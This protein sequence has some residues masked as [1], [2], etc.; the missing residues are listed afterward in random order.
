M[1]IRSSKFFLLSLSGTLLLA[2]C[3]QP[4]TPPE[5]KVPPVVTVQ[6][7]QV[8]GV[9]SV[10]RAGEAVAGATVSVEGETT[11]T[12]TDAN[13]RYALAVPV[14]ASKYRNLLITK[15]DYASTR[16]ENVDVSAPQVLNEILQR[17]FDPA[18]PS[19]PPKVTVVRQT[20]ND[21]GEVTSSA[22]F[23]DGDTIDVSSPTSPA[24]FLEV[25]TTTASPDLNGPATG[26]ASV[27]AE[28]GSSG[29]LNNGRTRVLLSQLTGSDTFTFKAADLAAFS[30]NTDIHINIYDYN[31]NRTH[32]IRH[33]KVGSAA[34]T[35]AVIAPTN[36]APLAIT[37]ADTATYGKLSQNPQVADAL[38]AWVKTGNA[39]G[40]RTLNQASAQGVSPQ[41]LTPQAA[42]AGTVTW[43]D[44]NF[45]YDPAA[46]QPRSFELYRSLDGKKT[47][48]KVLSAAPAR[49]LKDAKKPETG[50]F[51]M[52][53]NSAE[54]TPGTEVSYKVRAVSDAGGQDS[55]A[56]S[57]TPLGRYSI[58]LGAPGRAAT[59]VDTQPIFRWKTRGASDKEALL[60]LLLDRTQAEG[61]SSQWESDVSDSSSVIYNADWLARTPYLQPFHA[62]DWQLAGVTYNTAK[63]A[64]SV[65][66]DYFNVLGITANP[67]KSGPI[68]EFVTGGY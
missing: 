29:Y 61:K 44:V 17:S 12:T 33:V 54:L 49:V 59:G 14:T 53:D 55:E 6:T 57:V 63:T 51:L 66:A 21:K 1:S 19:T 24:L 25:T 20:K 56:T 7:V 43:V 45:K 32:L 23:V 3:S 65:G 41:L 18:L 60:L 15:A 40:L 5:I 36:L 64:Y 9:V 47:Y 27:G 46:P 28:A 37:F 52:R 31:G 68:N 39:T 34:V 13:G 38:S 58:E 48:S 26:I 50:L 8:T 11:K 30:G 42:E 4:G 22:P 2:A 67:V 10:A 35:G 16:V 62:Y